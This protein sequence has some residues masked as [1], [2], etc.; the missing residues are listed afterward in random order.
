MTDTL[1]DVLLAEGYHPVRQLPDGT[2][3]GLRQMM[4]TTGLFT[5]LDHYGYRCRY[6][7]ETAGQALVDLARWDG[8]GDPPGL[9]IKAKGKG[10]DR[11]NPR[12]GDPDFDGV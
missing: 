12:L 5:G 10:G 8:T 3:I 1:T 7:Y 11:L 6:C 4:Y 2:W 9:W